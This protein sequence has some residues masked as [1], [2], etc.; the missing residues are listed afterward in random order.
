MFQ[1]VEKSWPPAESEGVEEDDDV[2]ISDNLSPPGTPSTPRT[3][4][5]PS[6]LGGKKRKKDK[7][8][9]KSKAKSLAKKAKLEQTDTESL[10][11]PKTPEV[12]NVSLFPFSSHFPPTP[13]LIPPPIMHPLFPNLPFPKPIDPA[14]SLL[15]PVMPNSPVLPL[16]FM[17]P[18]AVETTVIEEEVTVE[19]TQV[20]VEEKEK[21][22]EKEKEKEK[23][24]KLEVNG[25]SIVLT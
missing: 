23:E 18:A 14:G 2:Y 13:G 3:P 1:I 8:K 12:P 19:E 17:Q 22:V 15:H 5:L 10:E 11:R 16:N 20:S 9:S 24:W 7:S 25:V 4:E 6:K 21:P